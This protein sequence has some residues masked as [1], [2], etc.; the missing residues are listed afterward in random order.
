M[1]FIYCCFTSAVSSSARAA[2]LRPKHFLRHRRRSSKRHP[3]LHPSACSLTADF[4]L[5]G[6]SPGEPDRRKWMSSEKKRKGKKRNRLKSYF[7]ANDTTSVKAAAAI[8]ERM[9]TCFPASADSTSRRSGFV[10]SIVSLW[11]TN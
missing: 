7:T 6:E 1:T 2:R 11:A 4:C 9:L 8:Q 5:R 10:R 3:L